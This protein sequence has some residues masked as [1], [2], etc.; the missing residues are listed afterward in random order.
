M[1]G[2]SANLFRSQVPEQKAQD[3]PR[4]RSG[5]DGQA[6]SLEPDGVQGGRLPCTP[7]D[8]VAA[9]ARPAH[10]ATTRTPSEPVFE[11]VGPVMIRSK[12][13]IRLP[14]KYHPDHRRTSTIET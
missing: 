6:D 2:E 4:D 12:L 9:L 7:D 10:C 13:E 11:D 5:T 1:N 8:L 3:T 14:Y